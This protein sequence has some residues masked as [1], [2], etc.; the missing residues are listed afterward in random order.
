MT[1]RSIP[2]FGA[3]RYNYVRMKRAKNTVD[4]PFDVIGKTLMAGRPQDWLAL[5]G[6][7]DTG[8]TP[9]ELVDA[10]LATLVQQADRVLLR[11]GDAAELYNL[12]IETGHHGNVLAE[13]LL[14]LE[15]GDYQ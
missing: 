12:E 1:A 14:L 10:D 2:R 4:K 7:T 13:R 6:V 15:R 3:A 9:I 8:A 11:G 5:I